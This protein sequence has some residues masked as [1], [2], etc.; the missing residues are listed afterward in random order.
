MDCETG[1]LLRN[2]GCRMYDFGFNKSDIEN[3]TSE[4]LSIRVQLKAA[5]KCHC[6]FEEPEVKDH[7]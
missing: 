7:I 5:D 2:F 3:P 1:R 6:L 4:I